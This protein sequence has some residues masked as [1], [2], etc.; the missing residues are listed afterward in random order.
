MTSISTSNSPSTP[1]ASA[2]ACACASASP[3]AEPVF[4]GVDVASKHLDAALYGTKSVERFDNSSTA[5]A[6]WLG[7]LAPSSC[8][9]LESTGRYHRALAEAAHTKGFA[10]YVLNP[11][12]VRSYA[13]S[14]GMRGKTDRLDA[15]VLARYLAHEHRELRCWQ[16]QPAEQQALDERLRQRGTVVKH[17]QALRM[18]GADC[19]E[20][21]KGMQPLMKEFVKLLKLM[22]KQIT[23]SVKALCA[24][25]AGI[26]GIKGTEGNKGTKGTKAAKGSKA[27]ADGEDAASTEAAAGAKDFDHITSVPGIGLLS[28]AAML[29]VFRRLHTRSADAVIAFLGLDPRPMDSGQKKGLRRLSKRGPPEW[30]RLL[31]NA[32]MSG[33]Q[34][35]AWKAHYERELDKGLPRVAALNVLARKM[36]RTAF[37]LFKS[38][39]MFDASLVAIK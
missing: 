28:G 20:L 24:P 3:P 2:S 37:G 34:T 21:N 19:A 25:A 17:Q 14:V 29:G 23:A 30:R 12:D 16:P 31:F 15:Q 10:V 8:I 33:C 18:S 39:S 36:V 32:A 9:A 7:K 13:R 35:K 4:I 6:R 11:R 38:G 1:L 26:K 27:A 5:I 22:D